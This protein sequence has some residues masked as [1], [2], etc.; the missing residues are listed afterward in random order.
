MLLLKACPHC[1]GDLYPSDDQDMECLQCS[2]TF[3]QPEAWAG[4]Q[5][6]LPRTASGT[7]LSEVCSSLSASSALDR[8]PPVF[9]LSQ[10]S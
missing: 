5:P 2:R 1:H 7:R 10:A 9:A 4:R 8:R 3:P 6:A